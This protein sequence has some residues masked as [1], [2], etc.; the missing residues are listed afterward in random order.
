MLIKSEKMYHSIGEY[1]AKCCSVHGLQFEDRRDGFKNTSVVCNIEVFISDAPDADGKEEEWLSVSGETFFAR[2]VCKDFG[3]RWDYSNK[4]WDAVAKDALPKIVEQA[5]LRGFPLSGNFNHDGGMTAWLGQ[6]GAFI[7][8][9]GSEY[10][11]SIVK[12]QAPPVSA[13]VESE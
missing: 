1:I 13:P 7:E 8:E 10:K 4:A 3:G 9:A 5:W 6:H 12:G 2:E 11:W